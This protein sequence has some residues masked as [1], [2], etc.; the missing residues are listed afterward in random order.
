M[1]VENNSRDNSVFIKE[2]RSA[3]A[4]NMKTIIVQGIIITVMTV[5]AVFV[6]LSC[7]ADFKAVCVLMCAC[8]L[9]C[10]AATAVR[11]II[12]TKKFRRF[13][14][15]IY[16]MDE[17]GFNGL[18]AQA[19][20]AGRDFDILYMLDEYIYLCPKHVLIP[21][22]DVKDAHFSIAG[23]LSRK[24]G[25]YFNVYCHSGKKY[26]VHSDGR[27]FDYKGSED[28]FKV[29]LDLKIRKS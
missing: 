27:Y 20:S 11:I 2:S 18:N 28:T 16:S 9:A 24:S 29:M 1:T 26:A 14:E 5:F 22:Y 6:I 23:V 8:V 19:V 13:T 10:L 4:E 25:A 15:F 21:Y 7:F 12:E 17:S 3:H